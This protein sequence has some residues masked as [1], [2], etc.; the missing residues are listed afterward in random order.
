MRGQSTSFRLRRNPSTRFPSATPSGGSG[1][2]RISAHV[3]QHLV[4]L[5]AGGVVVVWAALLTTPLTISAAAVAFAAADE[6]QPLSNPQRLEIGTGAADAV[7]IGRISEYYT[8]QRP[9]PIS[10]IT[11][12]TRALKIR[13]VHPL[14]GTVEPGELAVI[15]PSYGPTQQEIEQQLASSGG[16]AVIFLKRFKTQWLLATEWAPNRG[17]IPSFAGSEAELG[18]AELVKRQEVDSLA[19]RAPLVVVAR[20]VGRRLCPNPEGG[21]KP[22]CFVVAVDSVIAGATDSPQLFIDPVMPLSVMFKTALLF[23]TPIRPGVYGL[24]GSHA[25]IIPIVDVLGSLR[26]TEWRA[27]SDRVR[28]LRANTRSESK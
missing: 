13:D 17:V 4:G 14:K 6:T 20:F 15:I 21:L 26:A 12:L 8:T 25:G 24:V 1:W 7:V 9:S 22:E 28:R 27:T 2:A 18:V 11:L 10:G 5:Q 3:T 16:R 19:L 23:L